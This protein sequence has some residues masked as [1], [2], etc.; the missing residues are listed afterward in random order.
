MVAS[1]QITL[2]VRFPWHVCLH[3]SRPGVLK[4]YQRKKKF[5]TFWNTFRACTNFDPA[6][7]EGYQSDWWFWW[8]NAES[9]SV[10]QRRSPH[11]RVTRHKWGTWWQSGDTQQNSSNLLA[12]RL[13]TQPTKSQYF[14]WIHNKTLA[15][16]LQFCQTHY[17]RDINNLSRHITKL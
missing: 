13:D 10:V 16:Y 1:Y 12:V 6:F 14:W 5:T 9:K 2:V 8:K 11:P 17:R 4:A 7:R 15:I 3:T